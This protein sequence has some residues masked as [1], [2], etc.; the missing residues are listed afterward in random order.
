MELRPESI[1]VASGRPHGPR[2]PLQ[3]PIVLTA[4]Y[5]NDADDNHYARHTVTDT[6][7]SFEAALGALE[8]G[9]SLAF[10]SGMA[11][12]AAI[13]DSRPLGTVAVVPDAAYSGAT[14]TFRTMAA[15]GRMQVRFVDIADTAAVAA[16]LDG[17]DLL[18]VE[19]VSNPLMVVAD[20]PVLIGAA[21]ERGALVGVDATFATPLNVRPLELGADVAMHSVTK[22][23]AGHSDVLMGALSVRSD[24]LLTTLHDRRTIGGG[25]PG[26]LEAYLATRGHPHAGACAWS[27]RRRT[28]PSSPAACPSTR[29]WCGCATPACRPTRCTRSP[30]GCWTG[31]AP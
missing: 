16:A 13:A 18:W 20:L 22:Y 1:V 5:R 24:E 4:P 12:I 9:S 15:S 3:T 2:A 8:G 7:T 31:S 27:A 29:R 26:A 17:A 21:H 23:L 11:A 19:A 6:V 25:V 14:T 28:R 30:R 10:A